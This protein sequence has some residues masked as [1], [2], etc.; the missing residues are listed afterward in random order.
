MS[1]DILSDV[2][3]KLIQEHKSTLIRVPKRLTETYGQTGGLLGMFTGASAGAIWGSSIGI[4]LGGTAIA[5]TL[6]LLVVGGVV[7]YFGGEKIG[8]YF[9]K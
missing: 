5:G 3:E 4:A 1:K 7:G 6:P 8:Q 9:K 2:R